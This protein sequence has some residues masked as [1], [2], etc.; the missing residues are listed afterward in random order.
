MIHVMIQKKKS[1]EEIKKNEGR[2]TEFVSIVSH[3][4]R[5]PLSVIRGYLEALVNEDQ[6]KLNPEQKE[7]LSDT[8][9]INN[10]MIELV[11][12]YLNAAQL[13]EGTIK[14]HPEK[15]HIEDIVEETVENMMTFAKASNCELTFQKP[16]TPL[17]EV[18]TDVIKMRQVVENIISNAVKYTGR[19]GTVTTSL[20]QRD[21]TVIFTCKDSGIG[22][23]KDQQDEIF[24][25]FFRGHN[26]IGHDTQGSGLGLY[27]AK[28]IITALKGKI[29]F[30]SEEG[31]GTAMHVSIPVFQG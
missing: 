14:V 18:V 25:R 16:K 7:Y 13:D 3:Q 27:T 22:I 20:E 15:T 24:T 28:V 4:L 8:L 6:G 23:P 31:K 19:G 9:R 5:T 11:N 29:W 30:D 2:R 17:P 12:D 10:E 26:V 1:S 21:Q